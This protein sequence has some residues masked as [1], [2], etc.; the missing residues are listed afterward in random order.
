MNETSKTPLTDVP[1]EKLEDVAGGQLPPV[2]PYIV[3]TT[4]HSRYS[5]GDT[6]KYHVGQ[7]VKVFCSTP[8]GKVKTTCVILSV[9]DTANCGLFC[10]EFGYR[11][12]ITEAVN[13]YLEGE[14]YPGVYE[15]CLY[16][17]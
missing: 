13:G 10:K 7:Y 2:V 16:E 1:E 14:T 5:S 11:I 17:N 9:S 3:I 4:N 6:P 8:L 12:Q 15:S